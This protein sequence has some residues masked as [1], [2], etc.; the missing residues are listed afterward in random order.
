MAGGTVTD[1]TAE[2]RR[3]IVDAARILF[4]REGL[5]ATTMEKIARAA[6]V[7]K[8]TLYAH[9]SDK[10]A[11]FDAL[12]DELAVA[13]DAEFQA[14]LTGPGDVAQRIGAAMAGKFGALAR[15]LENSPVAEELHGAHG[16]VAERLR[17][18]E[19]AMN[20]IT[21]SELRRAGVAEPAEL[22]RIIQAACYG[23]LRKLVDESEVRAAIRLLCER[24]IRPELSDPITQRS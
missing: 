13:K 22:N 15:L 10:D 2:K 4:V 12:L 20:D 21:V 16:R 19:T 7:A 11:I 9:F 3:R 18:A 6:G 5:R 24:L 1:R 14:G 8:P 17:D 23:L